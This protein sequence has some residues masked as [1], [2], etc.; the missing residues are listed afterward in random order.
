MAFTEDL[1]AFFNPA[2]FADCATL[3]G[4]LVHGIFD[5]AYQVADAGSPGVYNL[6]PAFVLASSAVPSSPVGSA[7]VVQNIRYTV[8]EAQPDGTG[9]TTLLLQAAA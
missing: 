3:A 6:G 7:L 2:E 4:R 9:I 8:Q 1:S 5:R